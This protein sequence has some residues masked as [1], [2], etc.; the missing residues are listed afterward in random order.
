M[1]ELEYL[2]KEWHEVVIGDHH[3]DSDCRFCITYCMEYGEIIG[4]KVEHYAYIGHE[5]D[6]MVYDSFEEAEE[7]LISYLQELIE[8][9]RGT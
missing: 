3:K 2:L 4:W 7:A 1:S 8:E 9:Y 5:P 6:Y